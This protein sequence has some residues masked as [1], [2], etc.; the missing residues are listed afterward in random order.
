MGNEDSIAVG[1]VAA[2]DE[3]WRRRP[4]LDYLRGLFMIAMVI[5]HNF[6]IIWSPDDYPQLISIGILELATGIYLAVSGANVINFLAKARA[7]PN[8]DAMRFY[9]KASFWLFVMGFSYNLI[10]GTPGV[11]D[12]IQCVAIGTFV[13]FLLLYARVRN[14]LVGLITLAFFA[15]GALVHSSTIEIFPAVQSSF[16]YNQLIGNGVVLSQWIKGVHPFPYM[17]NHYGPIPWI[18]YFTLGVFLDR[19]RGKWMWAALA[20]SFL[21]AALGAYLPYLEADGNIMQ[22]YRVNPRFML[23]SVGMISALYLLA[24]LFYR[25]KT[26]CNQKVAFW[27]HTSLIVFVF[28]WF[29]IIAAGFIVQMIAQVTDWPL[30]HDWFRYPRALIAFTGI[31]LA[32][33]PLENLRLRWSKSPHFE[34][35]GRKIMIA[36]FVLAILS[37]PFSLSAKG[38]PCVAIFVGVIGYIGCMMS[39]YSFAF[40]YG[41]LRAKWSKEATRS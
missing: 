14:S 9:V 3:P 26:T 38:A 11:M 30:F 19:L 23:Q 7:K 5:Y 13:S 37:L 27:S 17:F 34:S 31:A 41:F 4:E 1:S 2:S 24:K 6:R 36:G 39:A 25:G 33:R 12:L 28:H 15:T 10:V 21:I 16:F 8:F 32:L 20:G 40:L 18:G 22:A 35:R 29:F